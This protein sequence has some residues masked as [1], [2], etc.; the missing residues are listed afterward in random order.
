MPQ[1]PKSIEECTEEK[2]IPKIILEEKGKKMIFLNNSRKTVKVITVDGC[3]ITSGSKCDFLVKNEKDYECFVELKGNDVLY[4][5]EQLKVSIKQLAVNPTQKAKHSF[6]VA[7][8][9]FPSI[10]TRIQNLKTEFKKNFNCTLI[11]KNQQCD[12]EL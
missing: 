7:S 4:A 6:V 8:R 9:V 10:T 2:S 12:F 3:A 11:I 5:C 1:K